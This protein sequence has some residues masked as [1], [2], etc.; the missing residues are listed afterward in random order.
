[1]YSM[2]YLKSEREIAQMRAAGRIVAEAFELLKETI[3]PGVVLSELDRVTEEFLRKAGALPLYKGYRGSRENYPP[4][5]AVICTA[6]N[7]EICHGIPNERVLQEGD[8]VGVDIGLR[9][10][11]YCSDACVT[12][13][14]GQI[15]EQAQRL[16]D[17]AQECLALGISVAEPTSHLHDIGKVIERHA[18]AQGYSVVEDLTGHGIGRSLHEVPSVFHTR[19]P[20]R[21]MKLRPGMVFTIEPMINVGTHRHRTLADGW[22]EVTSDGLLSAQFEHTIAITPNGPE[23]LTRL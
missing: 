6:V 16:L 15:S 17:V 5:P 12:Y 4:F 18:H 14:V 9:Y 23:V 7:D 3:R 13:A 11:H 10:G 1:M 8:I 19:R 21:G 22:T 2:I 20:G